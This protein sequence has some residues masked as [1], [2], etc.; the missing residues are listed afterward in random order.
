MTDAPKSDPK[1]VMIPVKRYEI[2]LS[3]ED[4]MKPLTAFVN[5]TSVGQAIANSPDMKEHAEKLSDLAQQVLDVAKRIEAISPN[6][7]SP[8]SGSR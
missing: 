2:D 3:I 4:I 5:K 7:L 8:K 6:I 1:V